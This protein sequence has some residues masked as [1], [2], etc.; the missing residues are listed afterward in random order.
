[1]RRHKYSSERNLG[2]LL[3]MLVFRS[4]AAEVSVEAQN[5]NIYVRDGHEL[6]Q[7]TSTGEDRSPALSYDESKVVFVRDLGK[8]DLGSDVGDAVGPEFGP[9]Q[10]WTCDVRFCAPKLLLDSPI[11]IRGRKFFGFYSPQFSPDNDYLFF[12]IAFAVSTPSIVRIRLATGEQTYLTD[13]L[14]FS[15]IPLGRYR[16]DLIVQQHRS[17]MALGY[18]DWFYLFTPEGQQLGVIGSGKSD[19]YNFLETYVGDVSKCAAWAGSDWMA[20]INQIR[21]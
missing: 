1:M 6:R 8:R 16:G 4:Y 9:S 20:C 12:Q 10:L 2:A 19:V 7:L 21:P 18:Y 14:T 17:K 11:R 5:G 15:D 3:L 13:A